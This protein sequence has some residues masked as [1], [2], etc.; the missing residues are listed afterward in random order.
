MCPERLD[1]LVNLVAPHISKRHCRS[2]Q[3]IAPEECLVLTLRYLASGDSQQSQ[4]FN[5][6][7]GRSTV[8]KIIRETC[9]GIWKAL[10]VEYLKPPRYTED[11]LEI[12]RSTS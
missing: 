10:S 4:S 2:G 6:R 7:I 1:H 5:F 11:W 8:T 3:S 12:A 9:D